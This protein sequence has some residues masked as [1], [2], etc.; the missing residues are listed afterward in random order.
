MSE[1][2]EFESALEAL[3]RRTAS[4]MA[5]EESLRAAREN[6]ERNSGDTAAQEAAPTTPIEAYER[7]V[8]SLSLEQRAAVLSRIVREGPQPFEPD[9]LIVESVERARRESERAYAVLLEIRQLAQEIHATADA[10]VAQ[11][12]TGID[13]L[14]APMSSLAESLSAF[15]VR[16]VRDS[17]TESLSVEAKKV[18][19]GFAAQAVKDIRGAASEARSLRWYMLAGLVITILFTAANLIITL[20]R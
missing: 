17:A 11:R 12:K 8:G 16:A 15:S 1:Q 3:N 2:S 5:D 9:W 13:S 14:V 6:D 10:V 18:F 7:Y 20:R 4:I 19:S